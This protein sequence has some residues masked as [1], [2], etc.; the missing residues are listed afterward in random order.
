MKKFPLSNP[1]FLKADGD[2]LTFQHFNSC[3]QDLIG[4]FSLELDRSINKWTG[5]CFRAVLP[6]LLQ[7]L[8]FKE[9]DIKSWGTSVS[10]VFQLYAK[11]ISKRKEVHRSLLK[12]MDQIKAHIEGAAPSF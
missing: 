9:E 7:A 8:G 6:T 3:L 10:S 5:H 12:V 2:I 4:H 1:L 11:D